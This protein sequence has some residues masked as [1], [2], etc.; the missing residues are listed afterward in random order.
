MNQRTT[1]LLFRRPLWLLV[2][3]TALFDLLFWRHALGLNAALFTVAV[4]LA[5]VGAKGWPVLPRIAKL[6]A[7]GALWAAVLVVVQGT[8]LSL[9]ALFA[10]LVVFV[11]AAQDAR[12]RTATSAALQWLSGAVRSPLVVLDLVTARLRERTYARK[13]THWV[14]LA[15]VPLLVFGLFLLLYSGGNSRFQAVSAGFFDGVGDL[16][17]RFFSDILTPHTI[18]LVFGALVS[19][20]FVLNAAPDGL[21]Q[22]IGRLSD[23]LSRTRV[24]RPKWQM[25]LA[26]GALDREMRMGLLLLVLVNA[27]LAVVNVIDIHWLWFGYTVPEG[28]SLKEFVHQGTWL[29]VV[30]ILLGMAIILHLFRGNLNFHPRKEVLQRWAML[31]LVQNFILGISVCLRNSYYIGFHGLA[32]KRIGVMVFLLL[33]L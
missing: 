17:H 24:R 6:V 15:F 19:C 2:L 8:V 30:S 12:L 22:Y 28:G 9:W 16:L 5:V 7:A 13:G 18:F 10:S 3:F 25:P 31:W 27:L 29:L 11:G 23:G 14:G 4:M 20:G 32:Y 33:M 26:L 1:F 21:P